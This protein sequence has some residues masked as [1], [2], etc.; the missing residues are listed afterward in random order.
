[1]LVV[2]LLLYILWVT[3]ETLK[4]LVSKFKEE[5]LF[6]FRFLFCNLDDDSL[7]VKLEM[8]WNQNLILNVE[9]ILIM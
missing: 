8:K 6:S 3:T 5:I 4:V 1:M 7:L 9:N 2:I